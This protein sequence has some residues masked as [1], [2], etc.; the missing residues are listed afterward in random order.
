MRL[1]SYCTP[2]NREKPIVIPSGPLSVHETSLG[3]YSN[4]NIT[5]LKLNVK[6]KRKFSI[7]KYLVT[8][9][10]LPLLLV[11]GLGTMIERRTF[12]RQ[13][14]FYTMADFLLLTVSAFK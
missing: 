7:I 10:Q 14:K 1:L 9:N 12:K 4:R 6:I 13:F 11:L 2:L 3:C 8:S 5:V